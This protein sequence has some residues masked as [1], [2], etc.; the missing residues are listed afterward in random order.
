MNWSKH[1][2]NLLFME[3]EH[4]IILLGKSFCPLNSSQ[5]QFHIEFKNRRNN[6]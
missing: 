5:S 6:T 1:I 3:M 4:N 2:V